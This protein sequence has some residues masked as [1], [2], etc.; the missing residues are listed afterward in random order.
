[1]PSNRPSKPDTTREIKATPLPGYDFATDLSERD[2]W[3]RARRAFG[4]A[5]KEEKAAH[6]DSAA[7]Y[8]ELSLQYLTAID[9]G[10]I[11][12]SM[13]HVLAMQRKVQQQYD[14]F[15]AG[16]KELPT[17][18]GAQAVLMEVEP[19]PAGAMEE[20]LEESSDAMEDDFDTMVVLDPTIRPISVLPPIP[21][22]H[23]EH[24]TSA[25]RFFQGRGHKV[26]LD[27][28]TRTAEVFPRIRPILREEGV[29]E[30]LVFL[31]MIESGLKYKAYSRAKASGLWQFI[32]S[33]GRIYGLH[34]SRQYDERRHVEKAT[35][36]ACRYLRKLYNQFGDWYL[37]MAAYNCGEMRIE[38]ETRR[39]NTRDFWHLNR[40]PAQT[41]NYVPTYLA[42]RLICENPQKYGF[43]PLPKEQP[44]TCRTVW[45]KGFYSL[46]E[47]ARAAKVSEDELVAM[48]PEFLHGITYSPHDS[49]MVRLPS[50]SARDVAK[51]LAAKPAAR[52]PEVV[53][54]RVRRGE[55]LSLIAKKYRTTVT[56]IL[57][58]PDNASVKPKKL[59]PGQIVYIP[60]GPSPQQASVVP[61]PSVKASRPAPDSRITYTV[62]RGQ[63]LGEIASLLG[64]SVDELCTWNRIRNRNV[65]HPG[66]KLVVRVPSPSSESQSP[67]KSVP[68]YH[69]VRRGETL[70]RIA[71][72]YGRQ[73]SEILEW[74]RL[75]NGDIIYPGQKLRIQ[76]E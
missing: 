76:P 60:A 23:N 15:L 8:Y 43:P 62:Q 18:A 10:A 31:S 7:F 54:H 22:V 47:I 51:S 63:T 5:Q 65:I 48:N 11:D 68:S 56:E 26:M 2:K 20:P 59:R 45:V 25:I 12:I 71:Q 19:S 35:R 61:S 57:G 64:V 14:T 3:V 49:V 16:L 53:E 1:M 21:I 32:P 44:W 29:P 4:K 52:L 34:V 75:S 33:T 73:T 70:W 39:H 30:E 28:M 9:L 13:T 38:R 24:V 72:R 27:W 58:L 42:A 46:A 40:L 69:T 55:S 41:R 17:T 67:Q 74:N 6:L 50:G 37:A 36:A 66:Q